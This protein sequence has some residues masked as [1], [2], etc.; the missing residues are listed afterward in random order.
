MVCIA[1]CLGVVTLNVLPTN[2]FRKNS[3]S[4]DQN[5]WFGTWN[6]K[7]KLMRASLHKFYIK[8]FR[9]FRQDHR[10]IQTFLSIC[11]RK[12][13]HLV[14]SFT[15]CFLILFASGYKWRYDCSRI[16][17]TMLPTGTFALILH[18]CRYSK[19]F[20]DCESWKINDFI[21]GIL[22]N[23]LSRYFQFKIWLSPRKKRLRIPV[24]RSCKVF[25]LGT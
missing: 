22:K 14:Q 13:T 12:F 4:K 11:F 3:E 20:K 10:S 2:S 16:F 23:Q 7:L 1:K 24:G 15:K 19:Y 25:T 18:V 21:T 6:L 17:R 8:L 9:R 5:T